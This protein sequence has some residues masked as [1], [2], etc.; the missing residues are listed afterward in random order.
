MESQ[1]T[2]KNICHCVKGKQTE[3][4]REI[5]EKKLNFTIYTTSKSILKIKI[6]LTVFSTRG[7]V[8]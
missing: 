4:E 3:K 6:F 2:L 8:R 1:G 5:F 7:M